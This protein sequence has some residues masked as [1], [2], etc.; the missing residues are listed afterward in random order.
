MPIRGHAPLV[1]NPGLIAHGWYPMLKSLDLSTWGA[2]RTTLSNSAYSRLSGS[3]LLSSYFVLT[4]VL[5]D[6]GTVGTYKVAFVSDLT[7]APT[8]LYVINAAYSAAGGGAEETITLSTPVLLLPGRHYLS[9]LKDGAAVQM[10]YNNS[11]QFVYIN[12]SL[13]MYCI[14][15]NG[16]LYGYIIPIKIVGYVSSP[17]GLS[18][19]MTSPT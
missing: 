2:D 8:D 3:F 12:D 10:D 15:F 4:S 14:S 7:N 9:I 1:R 11:A 6:I 18:N 16:A 17:Q 5:W 13:T 19:Y